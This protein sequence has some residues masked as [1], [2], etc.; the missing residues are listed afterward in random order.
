[1]EPDDG[2]PPAK[3]PAADYYVP[4]QTAEALTGN[5]K[6]P[7]VKRFS[8]KMLIG[9]ALVAGAVITLAFTVGLQAPKTKPPQALETP[10]PP[11]VPNADVNALPNSYEEVIPQLGEQRP[12]DLAAVNSVDAAGLQPTG[13]PKQLTPLEQYVEQ[14]ELDRLRNED[15]ARGATV[16]FANSS[17]AD[18]PMSQVVPGSGEAAQLQERLLDLA[19]RGGGP[20]PTASPAAATSSARDD[21]NRQDDKAD[22][23]DRPRDSNFA[24][25]TSVQHPDF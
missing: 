4:P 15:R 6:A 22:F 8:R 20:A 25:H 21:A 13:A 10:A 3:A 1:M 2:T 16:S 14:A 9:I 5:A 23:L 7:G 24:L 17:G 12:G 18:V 11:P 19:Q